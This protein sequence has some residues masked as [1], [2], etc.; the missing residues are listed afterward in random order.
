MKRLILHLILGLCIAA[1]VAL[2]AAQA[3]SQQMHSACCQ[4]QQAA[5][6]CTM[7]CADDYAGV[8]RRDASPVRITRLPLG[9]PLWSLSTVSRCDAPPVTQFHTCLPQKLHH[10][11]APQKRYL[12]SC[13][14]RL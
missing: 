9:R 12:L 3:C 14:F 11:Y 8:A 1:G 5:S 6:S 4:H 10:A 7:R 13:A 2:P